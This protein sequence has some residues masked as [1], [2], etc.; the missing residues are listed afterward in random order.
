MVLRVVQWKDGRELAMKVVP[1]RALD[2]RSRLA[3]AREVVV[4]RDLTG[5][6]NVA[7]F[8]EAFEDDRNVYLVTEFL[9]GGDLH[10]RIVSHHNGRFS[11]DAVLRLAS[12]MFD[13]VGQL[14]AK[15]IAHR[16][17]KLENFVFATDASLEEQQ[18]KLIDF[19]LCHY[20]K[21]GG[22]LFSRVHCGTLQ[23]AAPEVIKGESY[24]P[25]HADMWSM[26]VVLFAMLTGELP[27]QSVSESV[28]RKQII[29]GFPSQIA[30]RS[31]I[32]PSVSRDLSKLL[33][34]LMTLDTS[35]RPT[36]IAAGRAIDAILLAQ[37][38]DSAH[39]T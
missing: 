38:Q 31:R 5:V 2:N 10:S 29:A 8:E 18:I 13:V 7:R 32:W 16:D 20:R 12:Q 19:G 14:H 23:F 4:S 1:K 3:L 33:S 9:A 17:I 6:R 21:P 24:I 35:Q 28:L 27:F 30:V 15:G 37:R 11:E 26:G 25:E 36:A 34:S 39:C 22:E